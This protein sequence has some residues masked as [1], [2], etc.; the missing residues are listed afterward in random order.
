MD[1]GG[2]GRGQL[3]LVLSEQK[4]FLLKTFAPGGQED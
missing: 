3:M 1:C 4:D 2:I